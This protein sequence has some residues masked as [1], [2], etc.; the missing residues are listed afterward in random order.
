M[1]IGPV[2]EPLGEIHHRRELIAI[3]DSASNP[4]RRSPALAS[5][6]PIHLDIAES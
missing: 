3:E 6:A 5:E 4:G 1:L 2:P